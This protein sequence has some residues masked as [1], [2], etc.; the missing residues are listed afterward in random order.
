M[1]NSGGGKGDQK[2]LLPAMSP[3]RNQGMQKLQTM[4]ESSIKPLTQTE[5]ITAPSILAMTK[6]QR[7]LQT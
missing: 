3:D 6:Q 2:L 7:I 5:L 4:P 1:Y